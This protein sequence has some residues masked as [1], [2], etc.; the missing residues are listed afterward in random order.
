MHDLD[1]YRREHLERLPDLEKQM[2]EPAGPGLEV[3]Q[4][5]PHRSTAEADGSLPGVPNN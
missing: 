2:K 4:P 3:I 5:E 1:G